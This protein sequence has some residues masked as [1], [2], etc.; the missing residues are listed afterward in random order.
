MGNNDTKTFTEVVS[1]EGWHAAFDPDGRATV[2]VDASFFSGLVGAEDDYDITFRVALKR[3]VLRLVIPPTEPIAAIQS[4]VAREQTAEGI[5]KMI[6]STS[7]GGSASI[8]IDASLNP[9]P[10]KGG[11]S[12]STSASRTQ[13]A[14]SETEK[15]IAQFETR[16]F[17][18]VAG[19][20]CWEIRSRDGSRLDGKVWDP[21]KRPRLQISRRTETRI[22]PVMYAQVLCRRCDIEITDVKPKKGSIFQNKFLANRLAAAKA[23]IKAKILGNGLNHPEGENDLIEIQIAETVIAEEVT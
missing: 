8:G 14:I 16:Q 5:L 4:S 1:L 21:V 7:L 10:L 19:N 6:S 2:H 11:V 22:P 15:A 9:V 18:D 3:A 23:V 12:A 20:Y 17:K 13:S